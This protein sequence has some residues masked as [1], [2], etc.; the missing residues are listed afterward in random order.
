[1]W[2]ERIRVCRHLETD[3]LRLTS[4]LSLMDRPLPN[5]TAEDIDE[6]VF[7]ACSSHAFTHRGVNR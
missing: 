5:E 7:A 1:M 2:T 3:I 6:E 4:F